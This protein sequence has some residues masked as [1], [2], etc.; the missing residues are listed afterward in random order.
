MS[1]CQA[2]QEYEK[3]LGHKTTEKKINKDIFLKQFLDV[4]S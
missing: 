1:N 4:L 3:L 2:L